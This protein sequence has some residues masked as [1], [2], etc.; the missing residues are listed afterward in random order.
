[1]Q[2]VEWSVWR[3]YVSGRQNMYC[4]QLL[5]RFELCLVLGIRQNSWSWV[6]CVQELRNVQKPSGTL[7]WRWT[8]LT[9]FM[10]RLQKPC[11]FPDCRIDI[12][13]C[14]KQF[15]L[16]VWDNPV[17]LCRTTKFLG[18]FLMNLVSICSEIWRKLS[19][20]FADHELWLLIWLRELTKLWLH[21]PGCSFV[22]PVNLP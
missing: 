12:P 15:R 17:W 13:D 21:L 20:P 11:I 2:I 4:H 14:E 19:S 8:R 7:A 10:D 9:L 18:L 22:V 16:V 1:M 6:N 5:D 3:R